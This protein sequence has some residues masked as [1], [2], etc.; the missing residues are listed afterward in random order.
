MITI[1]RIIV[2]IVITSTIPEDSS[3][4]VGGAWSGG[5]PWTLSCSFS[6]VV[7]GDIF[8]G[9]SILLRVPFAVLPRWSID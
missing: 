2:R 1:T 9:S 8:L 7:G 3:R 6:S 4:V 5:D